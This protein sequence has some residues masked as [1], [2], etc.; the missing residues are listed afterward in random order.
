MEKSRWKK[1]SPE[2]TV[3]GKTWK[4]Q[5][6]VRTMQC[7]HFSITRCQNCSLVVNLTL[8]LS[9]VRLEVLILEVVIWWR[10]DFG[11]IRRDLRIGSK[12][13]I[14]IWPRL[15]AA[16]WRVQWLSWPFL[17][18]STS[19]SSLLWYFLRIP[20]HHCQSMNC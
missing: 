4:K 9:W 15:F 12:W 5:D 1:G 18:P 13:T 2:Q 7:A 19:L 11:W 16:N 17:G 14:G 20:H 8:L 6:R 3:W 10:P